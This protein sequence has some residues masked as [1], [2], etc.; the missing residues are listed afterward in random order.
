MK[1]SAWLFLKDLFPEKRNFFDKLL[2]E[3]LVKKSLFIS[4]KKEL[5]FSSLKESGL[6]GI[7]LLIFPDPTDKEIKK[8]KKIFDKNKI[9]V[10]SIHQPLED[11]L[12]ISL[13]KI[14]KLFKIAKLLEAK[15]IVIHLNAIAGKIKDG[16]FL[17]D[18]KK[19]ER[20]YEVKIGVENDHN[21]PISF[22]RPYV[23][24]SSLFS[25]V[26]IKNNLSIIFDTTHLAQSGGDI[27]EFYN[28]N[29]NRIINIHL[30]DYKKGLL[31][32]YFFL[33]KDMHMP[34]GD[35][36]LPIKNLLKILKK[37]KYQGLITL[38]VTGNLL[39]MIKSAKFIRNILNE[40]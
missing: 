7:E 37:D 4:N 17:S 10:L 28:Q 6:D 35:G 21:S 20:K 13:D 39:G 33:N 12:T 18:L 16:Q 32:K 23:S 14:N 24:K 38:E 40:N 15:V 2:V 19:L 29:K 9:E 34:L 25:E 26:I 22:F 8:A 36:T 27:L 5:I 1:I 31:N 30:S 3:N 11:L